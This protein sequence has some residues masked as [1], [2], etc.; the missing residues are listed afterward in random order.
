MASPVSA[1]DYKDGNAAGGGQAP[2]AN[3]ANRT[4]GQGRW[5]GGVSFAPRP[6]RRSGEQGKGSATKLISE[7]SRTHDFPKMNINQT[8]SEIQAAAG[9]SDQSRSPVG[10]PTDR[11]FVNESGTFNNP[12]I[13]G[14]QERL[15]EQNASNDGKDR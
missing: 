7:G 8:P 13:Q 14:S 6:S 15:K 3:R 4:N 11:E 2:L 5:H 12:V 1:E 9:I 10:K